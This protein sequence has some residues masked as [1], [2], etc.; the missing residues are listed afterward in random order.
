MT[1]NRNIFKVTRCSNKAARLHFFDIMD[2][3]LGMFGNGRWGDG[4]DLGLEQFSPGLRETSRN[5]FRLLKQLFLFSKV[6][7]PQV[8]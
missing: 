6:C 1:N 7:G 8:T 5:Y 3:D 4:R 2:F